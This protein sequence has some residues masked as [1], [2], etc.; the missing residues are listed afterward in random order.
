MGT[1]QHGETPTELKEISEKVEEAIK[2]RVAVGT[3]I[4]YQKLQQEMGM[5]FDNA[6]A[7]TYAIMAMVRKGDF[8]H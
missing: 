3:K 8:Q 2:R 6:K 1:S 5:R 4:S 7:I